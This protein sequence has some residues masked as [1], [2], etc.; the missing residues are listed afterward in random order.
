MKG[1]ESGTKK[2]KKKSL[3]QFVLNILKPADVKNR[4][5]ALV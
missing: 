2:K 4:M 3:E 5:Y 1:P